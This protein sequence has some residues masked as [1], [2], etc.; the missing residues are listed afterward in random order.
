MDIIRELL[1]GGAVVDRT[2]EGEHG[3]ALQIAIAHKHHLAEQLLR[4]YGAA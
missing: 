4:E 3:T 1:D 2:I